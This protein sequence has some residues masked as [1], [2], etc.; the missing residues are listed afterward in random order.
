MSFLEKVSEE[1]LWLLVCESWSMDGAHLGLFRLALWRDH[2]VG[3]FLL[4]VEIHFLSYHNVIRASK[5]FRLTFRG[6]YSSHLSLLILDWWLRLTN[7]FFNFRWRLR[8]NLSS[9][10]SLSLRVYLLISNRVFFHSD[11]NARRSH[12]LLFG[13]RIAFLLTDE[14]FRWLTSQPALI[15]RLVLV[16]WCSR[17]ALIKI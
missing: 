1:T 2:R 13:C 9:L 3:D 10:N 7:H 15:E 5:R 16:E 6:N 12:P 4:F 14:C 11:S 8:F 17:L